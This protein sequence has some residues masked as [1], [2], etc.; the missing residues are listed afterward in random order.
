M[1]FELLQH[2]EG[3]IRIEINDIFI[4][5]YVYAETDYIVEDTVDFTISLNNVCYF[6]PLLVGEHTEPLVINFL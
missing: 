5:T 3:N 1:Q 2:S 6:D 4:D